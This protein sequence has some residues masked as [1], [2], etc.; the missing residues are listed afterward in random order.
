MTKSVLIKSIVAVAVCAALSI[1]IFFWPDTTEATTAQE[2]SVALPVTLARAGDVT[3][4]KTYPV[5]IEGE[6]DVEIRPQIEGYLASTFVDE[7]DYVTKGSLLFK[8][9]DHLYREQY[10]EAAAN[11]AASEANLEKVS[12]ELDKVKKLLASNIISSVQLQTAESDYK[13]VRAAVMQS[14]ATMESARIRLEYTSIKAPVNGLVGRLPYRK[15]SF[16][17]MS[18]SEPLTLISDVNKV[19]AYF[20]LSEQDYL[21]FMEK[22]QKAPVQV[23]LLLANGQSYPHKGIIDAVN[24]VFEKNTGS[25]AIRAEFPN[26]DHLIRS[27]NTGMI[28]ME[29]VHKGAIL[30]PQESTYK[31]QD[32]TLVY[33]VNGKDQ[34][35]SRVVTVNGKSDGFFV[36]TEGLQAGDRILESGMNR[37]AEGMKINPVLN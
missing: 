12:I 13:A 14:K 11:L 25:I 2:V 35:E 34:I 24:G 4:F 3:T 5:S 33:L 17:T 26:P 28:R 9:D 1:T 16:I 31:L 27:G 22:Q 8:I 6:M 23:S 15:G 32:K 36:V 37:V 7:G 29:Q 19:R 10:N 21:P 20:S 30:I 18:N